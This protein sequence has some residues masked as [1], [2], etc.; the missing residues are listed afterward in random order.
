MKCHI[1][2]IVNKQTN[3]VTNEEICGNFTNPIND[4]VIDIASLEES[5]NMSIPAIIIEEDG[6]LLLLFRSKSKKMTK[7]IP[8]G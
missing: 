4:E 2:N 7:T 3:E 6:S 1:V 8:F 5:S